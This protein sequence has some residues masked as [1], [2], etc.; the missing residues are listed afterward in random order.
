L[1][2]FM[3]PLANLPKQKLESVCEIHSRYR[4]AVPAL[5]RIKGETPYQ[6]ANGIIDYVDGYTH[7]GKFLL[8]A[9]DGSTSLYPYSL[10]RFSGRFWA[11]DH[12]HIVKPIEDVLDYN[13]AYHYLRSLNFT[14]FVNNPTRSKLT[15]PLLKNIPF[16]VISLDEQ[17]RIAHLLDTMLELKE[18]VEKEA[19]LRRQQ[20]E[21]YKYWLLNPDG[22][23]ETM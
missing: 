15:L 9:Q 14:P 1:D 18:V 4:K 7:D 11:N 23:L 17:K 19:E 13:F 5:S 6:G 16:P 12:V 2:K 3:L 22:K 21:Y 10:R 20:L 8:I